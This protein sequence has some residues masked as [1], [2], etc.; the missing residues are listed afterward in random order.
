MHL[1]APLNNNDLLD[2]NEEGAAAALQ[3]ALDVFT[4]MGISKFNELNNTVF[5]QLT[6][7]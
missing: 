7:D 4:W 2:I 1:G 5:I 6:D 3:I